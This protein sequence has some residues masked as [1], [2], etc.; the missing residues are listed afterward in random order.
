MNKPLGSYSAQIDYKS[1]KVRGNVIT[2]EQYSMHLTVKRIITV[3]ST[4]VLEPVKLNTV[5]DVL[6]LVD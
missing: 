6:A 3:M 4:K 2:S 1:T 5:A